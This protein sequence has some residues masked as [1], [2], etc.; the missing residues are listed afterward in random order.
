[1]VTAM[2]AELTA[3]EEGIFANETTGA[4]NE[5]VLGL[6]VPVTP[7]TMA[8]IRMLPPTLLDMKTATV[9]ALDQVVVIG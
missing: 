5:N 6:Y 4:S 1:M 8:V 7:E 9:V 2:L 3:F